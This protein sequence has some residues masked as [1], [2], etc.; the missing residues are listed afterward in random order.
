MPAQTKQ[1]YEFGP[2]RLDTVERVLQRDGRPVPLSPKAFE[3]LLIL[4]E[5]SGHI[6]EKDELMDRV[7]ADSFVEE[8]NLKVTVSHLRKAL[9]DGAEDRQYIE[10][11]PRRGYRFTANVKAQSDEGPELV[12][13]ERSRTDVTI[14]EIEASSSQEKHKLLTSSIRRF[15]KAIILRQKLAL[16]LLV[17]LLI[18]IAAIAYMTGGIGSWRYSDRPATAAG[19]AP[20]PFQQITI[21][22]LPVNGVPSGGAVLS[23][24]GKLFAYVTTDNEGRQ[25]LWL[26]HVDGGEPVEL[27]PPT[28]MAYRGLAISPT[29]SSL[30]FSLSE[31]YSGSA[32]L[33]RLPVF[34]GVSEKVKENVTELITFSPD[35]ERFGFVRYDD[36]RGASA[37]VT[38]DSKGLDEREVAVRPA[39]LGFSHS[40]ASWSPDGSTIAVAAMDDQSAHKNNVFTVSLADGVVKRLTTRGWKDVR[41][42]VWLNDSSG[43]LASVSD[44]ST[45]TGELWHITYPEGEA[46]RIFTDLNNYGPFVSLSAD[47]KSLLAV[48]SQQQSNIWVAAANNLSNAKQITFDLLGNTNGWFGLDWTP[49]GR[50]IF[51]ALADEGHTLWTADAD[52]SNK[53]QLLP[54]GYQDRHQAVTYDGRYV[55]FESDR[56]GSTEIWR[57]NSDG[58]DLKQ[59]T[60]GGENSNPDVTPDGRW[61]IYRDRVN[62][63]WR[64]SIDGGEPVLLIEKPTGFPRVSPDGNLIACAYYEH[65]TKLAI[66]SV[67]GGEPLKLFDVARRATFTNGLRWTPDGK[68]VTY[69]D[70]SNG[71]WKQSLDGGEPQR[72]EGLPKEKLFSYGWSRD[73]NLFAFARGTALYDVVLIHDLR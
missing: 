24:D 5:S 39:N 45:Q 14:E 4:V 57:A 56:S 11:V 8:G 54:S 68:A 44:Q 23:P 71:I 46:H 3:V 51:T 41:R 59:L 16:S 67:Y 70:L 15:V 52:G 28:G 49:D 73:G 35:G 38:A 43:L 63:L 37:L 25:S 65:K 69:R 27:R 30:Y 2:F 48:R 6:V 21:K 53:K 58:S 9:E 50:I 34:G 31:G 32:V 61:V 36:A 33:Y 62:T 55:V 22:R 29:G 18:A 20:M 47:N 19:Y 72:L 13:L 12:L 26:G 66:F 40:S 60:T 17:V 1:I 7:W 42:T 10:T 64:A